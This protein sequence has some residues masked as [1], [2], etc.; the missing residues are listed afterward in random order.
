MK[1]VLLGLLVIATGGLGGIWFL[2]ALVF[3]VDPPELESTQVMDAFIGILLGVAALGL[4]H[5][6]QFPRSGVTRRRWSIA[7]GITV[8][9]LAGGSLIS[10]HRYT[11]AVR[12]RNAKAAIQHQMQQPSSSTTQKVVQTP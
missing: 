4:F 9:V 1:K 2:A 3:R 8:C 11:L 7:T 6:L 12:E 5:L 10:W